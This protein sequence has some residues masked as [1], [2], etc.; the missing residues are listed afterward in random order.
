[1]GDSGDDDD[2]RM[3]AD[4]DDDEEDEQLSPGEDLLYRSPP[5]RRQQRRHSGRYDD[6]EEEDEMGGR[7]GVMY[8]V[9]A[10]KANKRLRACLNCKMIKTFEQFFEEGCNN[11]DR[12]GLQGDKQRVEDNTT[13]NFSGLVSL[14]DP[15][16][17]W[18]AR[19]NGL[20]E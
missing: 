11:C 4:Q 9:T 5:G 15:A 20:S 8:S 6:D 13:A 1:M 12:L 2:F 10:P 19:Y 7:E 16:R 17:S 18:V 3:S 14:C